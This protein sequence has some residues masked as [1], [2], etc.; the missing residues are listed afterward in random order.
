MQLQ[1]NNAASVKVVSKYLFIPNPNTMTK[2]LLLPRAW[3]ILHS[4]S[5]PFHVF[6]QTWVKFR[7]KNTEVIKNLVSIRHLQCAFF[8]IKSWSFLI[9]I[10]SK[11]DSS[12]I[13]ILCIGKFLKDL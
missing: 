9:E 12:E 1:Y 8:F 13:H 2:K 6:N 5:H 11:I 7:K 4:S 10:V 3:Q